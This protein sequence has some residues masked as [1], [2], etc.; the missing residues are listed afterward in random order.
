MQPSLC[1]FARF[2]LFHDDNDTKHTSMDPVAFPKKNWVKVI[3]WSSM[4]PDLNPIKHPR[5]T[6]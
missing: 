1:A 5:D 2:A 6:C 3:P 4:S